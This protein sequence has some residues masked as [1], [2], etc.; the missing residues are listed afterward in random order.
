ME[1]ADCSGAASDRLCYCS[2]PLWEF[3]PLLSQ[4][5]L[6]VACFETLCS[7]RA[8]TLLPGSRSALTDSISS[9]EQRQQDF[10]HYISL[11]RLHNYGGHIF[12]STRKTPV[13]EKVESRSAVIDFFV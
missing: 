13:R 3:L 7:P 12:C 5:L 11:R 1:N 6:G 9:A 2:G 4:C 8:G 10:L